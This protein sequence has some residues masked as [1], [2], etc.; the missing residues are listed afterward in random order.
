MRVGS[1]LEAACPVSSAEKVEKYAPVIFNQTRECSCAVGTLATSSS[2]ISFIALH[3]CNIQFS[4][5][6]FLGLFRN[7]ITRNRRYSCSF[8]NYSVFGMNG[9]SFCSRKQNKQNERNT[10]QLRGSTTVLLLVVVP[11]LQQTQSS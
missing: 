5:G 7:R 10:V 6:V 3:V 8:G 4:K 1:D 9:I 2:L 11:C